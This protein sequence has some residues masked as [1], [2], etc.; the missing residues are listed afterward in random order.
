MKRDEGPK[1]EDQLRPEYW[2]LKFEQLC[3]SHKTTLPINPNDQ[4]ASVVRFGL[5]QHKYDSPS[6]WSFPSSFIL[7]GL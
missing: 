1:G 5:G 3:T 6:F 7:I 2:G 4:F